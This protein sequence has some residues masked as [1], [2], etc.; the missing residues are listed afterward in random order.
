M[1]EL[2][3]KSN[4]NND[5]ET[6]NNETKENQN[7]IITN[8]NNSNNN[9]NISS[10]NRIETNEILKKSKQISS[11]TTSSSSTE[12]TT[13]ENETDTIRRVIIKDKNKIEDCDKNNKNNIEIKK[14]EI[15]KE[16]QKNETNKLNNSNNIK[17][18]ETNGNEIKINKID[19]LE[20]KNNKTNNIQGLINPVKVKIVELNSIEPNKFSER[21]KFLNTTNLLNDNNTKVNGDLKISPAKSILTNGTGPRKSSLKKSV[22]FDPDDET[23]KKFIEGEIIVDKKNPFKNGF[24]PNGSDDKLSDT[25]T[26]QNNS[27]KKSVFKL[28]RDKDKTNKFSILNSTS[29]TSTEPEF[30]TTEEVLN[31][32]KYVKTY[33]KNPDKVFVY[34]PTILQRIR[35]EDLKELKDNEKPKEKK[36]KLSA[37]TQSRLKELRNKCS[38]AGAPLQTKLL[39]TPSAKIPTFKKVSKANYPDLSDIKVKTG[40][41]LEESLFSPEEVTKN[42]KKFD[43]RIKTLHI[44]S[45]DD[46]EEIDEP[47]TK[48]DSS[49]E[50][51]LVLDTT[52]KV[53]GI[54]SDTKATSITNTTTN[55]NKSFTNTVN[56]KEF[57]EYLD[58]KGLQLTPQ[59]QILINSSKVINTDS[60]PTNIPKLELSEKK[61]SNK[62]PIL[63]TT[64]MDQKKQK[65][66]S[67]LQRIKSSGFFSSKRKTTPK[68]PVPTPVSYPKENGHKTSLNNKR[69][70]L[71]R[72]SFHG[73]SGNSLNSS[74]EFKK[75][76]ERS[77]KSYAA[78]DD[79][80]SSIS[81]ALTNAEEFPEDIQAND[82]NLRQPAFNKEQQHRGPRSSSRSSDPGTVQI[83]SGSSSKQQRSRSTSRER[84]QN[85]HSSKSQHEARENLGNSLVKP[86]VQRPSL[87]ISSLK[88]LPIKSLDRNE[89]QSAT[90]LKRSLERQSMVQKRVTTPNQE[91][92]PMSFGRSASMDRHEIIKRSGGR[93]SSSL[94]KPTRQSVISQKS[95]SS[96][97][98]PKNS[99]EDLLDPKI[100]STPIDSKEQKEIKIIQ[101][102]LSPIPV[103]TGTSSTANTSYNVGIEEWN[104]L[105]EIKEKTDRELFNRAAQTVSSNKTPISNGPIKPE[106]IYEKVTIHQKHQQFNPG[107]TQE[108][109]FSQ[110]IQPQI[111]KSFQNDLQQQPLYAQL[112][113]EDNFVRGSPQRNTFSGVPLRN[114]NAKIIDG[115]P[116]NVPENHIIPIREPEHIPNGP[117]PPRSQSVL[118]EMLSPGHQNK[119]LNHSPGYSGVESDGM[120]TPVR[121][122]RKET[123]STGSTL[124][125]EEILQKVKEFCRKSMNKTPTKLSIANQPTPITSHIH[126]EMNGKIPSDI[127]PISYTSV[128]SH[129]RGNITPQRKVLA[130]QVPQ[131]IQSLPQTHQISPRETTPSTSPIY[132]HVI[133]R[134]SIQSN[135]SDALDSP[136]RFQNA[137]GNVIYTQ[138]NGTFTTHSPNGQVGNRPRLQTQT[139]ETDS[140]FLPNGHIPN[141]PQQIYIQQ[142]PQATATTRTSSSQFIIMESDKITPSQVVK[143]RNSPV[144]PLVTATGNSNND[145]Y[146]QILPPSPYGY[147]H[148]KPT[149][150]G[151]PQ[152]HMRS[153][154]MDG[155]STP[156]ILER[157]VNGPYQGSQIYWTPMQHSPRPLHHSPV[158][159]YSQL[160]HHPQQQQPRQ[161]FSPNSSVQR[162]N[163]LQQQQSQAQSQ[164][165]Q[166]QHYAQPQQTGSVVFLK[167]KDQIYR[168]INPARANLSCN[169]NQYQ[170]Q[171][172]VQQQSMQSPSSLSCQQQQQQQHQ[173]QMT[174]QMGKPR[175]FLYESESGSEAGEVQRIMQNRKNEEDWQNDKSGRNQSN[176]QASDDRRRAARREDPRRHT[177]GADMLQYGGGGMPGGGVIM[178]QAGQQQ[179]QRAM[180][181]EM[182]T[183]AQKSKKG[184]NV[185]GYTPINQGPLF[186]EDPGIMSEVETASTGFRRGN[187]QRSS[188]PVVRTPSKTLE[189]PLGLVFLQYRSETKRALLPNEITSIDTVRALFVRSFPRQ[190]TM[191]YLEGPNV[192]IYIHDASKDMFYELEDVR[193]HLREIRD[194]S[195]LRLFESNEVAAPQVLPGGPG[196]PQPLPQPQQGHWDQDQSYF[197]EPEFDSE[198]QHQHIHKS[199]GGKTAPYYVGAA[200]TLPRGMY[201]DRNKNAVGA[202]AK[203]LRSYGS[204]GSMGPPFPYPPDQLYSIPADGYTSSPERGTRGAYEEPYYSQYGTRGAPIAPIIT[205]EQRCDGAMTE[206]EYA[207]YGM[208]VSGR[209]PRNPN[210]LYDPT[211]PED[212]HR[213]RVEHMERQLANLT[214]LVQKALVNQN[215]QIIAH[216]AGVINPNFLGVPGQ[217]R[218]G[219]DDMD[220]HS[221]GSSTS[222]QAN[223]T[224]EELYIR[225]KPPKLGKSMS[226]KSVSFEKSVSFSDDIQ[227]VPKSHS[228]QHAADSKPPKPAIKSSTL[229]RTSSQER[230]R[231]KPPP[232]PKPLALAQTHPNYRPDIAL[233]PE[234]YNHLRGL[235]K[236]AK[237]LRMEVRTLRRLSQAQAVAVREDIKDAFMRIRATL[238]AGSGN[239]WGQGDQ[240]KTR[241]SREEELYKQEVIRLENDLSDLEASVEGLRGEVINRRTRV[242]MAAVEDMA[243][244]LSRASKTVAELKM[245]FPALQN[246]L[247]NILSNEMEKVVREEKFLKEEPDRL[248]SALRRCKKLTGTLVTLKRLA[249]VQEQRIPVNEPVTEDPPRSSEISSTNKPVPSPRMG[250]ITV[251]GGV[252]PENALDALLDELQTFAKPQNIQNEVRPDDSTSDDSSQTLHNTITTQL[253]QSSLYT[254]EINQNNCNP[255][256]LLQPNPNGPMGSLRRLHSYP[257]GSDTDTSPPQPIRPVGKPPVPERNAELLTKVGSKRIPPPPPPRTSSRSPLASPTSPNVPQRL[258]SVNETE[259][260]GNGNSNLTGLQDGNESSGNESG[261]DHVQRQLALEMRHQELLKKQK[262]LQEQYARLQQ[263]SKNAVALQSTDIMQLK[264]TGSESNLPQ[265]MGLN[266][267]VTGSMKNL[268]SELNNVNEKNEK[269]L[270]NSNNIN[271]EQHNIGNNSIGGVNEDNVK[272]INSN[273]TTAQQQPQQTTTNKIYETDIL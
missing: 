118:D 144:S 7:I 244:V 263:M 92:P 97:N 150:P 46:L 57:Q 130:P 137:G 259:Q 63:E 218:V 273:N 103:N 142:Q 201:S 250:T 109:Y 195:V 163:Q 198:Y 166:R 17:L 141:Q 231:L 269:N 86:K 136:T 98:T 39:K 214:G 196:I 265:K 36:S 152:L 149:P 162:T 179:Q 67:V 84:L 257:S 226:H 44:G 253:S 270:A 116:I 159:R 262:M 53:D 96:V 239:F 205:E 227:G 260:I 138:H 243:L 38:S 91:E 21:E 134:N 246:G 183:R 180:D 78:G 64:E 153:S 24:I 76:I 200:Q 203:P 70:I 119:I 42:A 272:Q 135:T 224:G 233:A 94:P 100:T 3:E 25:L 2:N 197:S 19:E 172:Q 147:I 238:L 164:P 267:S 158:P 62:I 161:Q 222:I 186:D 106:N 187:K 4:C 105:K 123:S 60:T 132:A 88:P 237:D 228:P 240:E 247:R 124:T 22:S 170:Q 16:Y 245:K 146:G 41:D 93:Q 20:K 206:D 126:R 165:T 229:P 255:N 81:S 85:F 256:T 18:N 95:V 48:S 207:L 101:K 209:I 258:P 71:E 225:E 133:K 45:D 8:N 254:A 1:S 177:L 80:S 72:Q 13:I 189:R 14:S 113:P 122:R 190:L 249:S 221:S 156:L 160:N 242:N 47:L 61:S 111:R 211:R 33:I 58:R 261:N 82:S 248:E 139:S 11:S 223:G 182:G 202:P 10:R 110:Q 174:L 241:I 87:P 35:Y 28:R 188:L 191:A 234:V 219:L 31:Q 167:V 50:L 37:Q 194:R 215:P 66:Q 5:N 171:P 117:Y 15:N 252:P 143:F 204:R 79:R 127:S 69:V 51:K 145:V 210:Q 173:N 155:R 27:N 114:R 75:H 55:E 236:K 52:D 176:D 99:K 216:P 89:K 83:N 175:A 168:P 73:S 208:K 154:R 43:E 192:K 30:I 32:S 199:K 140:V 128:D 56:S 232:P 74:N 131:R 54:S 125:R 220:G 26:K 6:I 77:R 102:P 213:I 268:N 264:K 271:E 230:D 120:G 184:Q 193:S 129:S 157:S 59:R 185:R 266:M 151:P 217:C 178:Q 49:D 29:T 9:N 235:Q 212:L 34:D 112:I 121:L 108:Q 107:A 148:L 181:L 251:S 40:T 23:I 12:T 65:K 169:T 104:K 115:N 68:E 90:P